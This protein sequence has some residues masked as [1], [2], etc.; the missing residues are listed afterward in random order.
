MPA[1]QTTYPTGIAAG[2]PGLWVNMENY[3]SITR[4]CETSA[5][6]GFGLAVS[7]GSGA[8]GA[9]LGGTVAGFLG[10][11]L[12]DITLVTP[13]GG[14]V[15]KY[16]R[17][18]NMGVGTLGKIW[19]SPFENVAIGDPVWFDGTTGRFGKATNTGIVGPIVGA[20]WESAASADGLAKV[21]L[22]IQK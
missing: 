2:K 8:K 9:I 4:I 5:G 1:V 10:V 6:I 21:S 20:A 17:Y 13:A 12:C 14:T 22:G 3:N 11:S 18:K 19:V 15:D 7:R 16:A